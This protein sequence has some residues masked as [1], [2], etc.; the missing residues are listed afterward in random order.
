[1]RDFVPV[2]LV[3]DLLDVSPVVLLLEPRTDVSPRVVVLLEPRTDVSPRVVVR[4]W[5]ELR[6]RSSIPMPW[7]WPRSISTLTPPP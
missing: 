2:V 6:S 7:R 1:M 4:E 5:I 3:P